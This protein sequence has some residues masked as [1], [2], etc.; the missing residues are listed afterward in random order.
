MQVF[1]SGDRYYDFY[2]QHPVGPVVLFDVDDVEAAGPRDLLDYSPQGRRSRSCLRAV[3][4]SQATAHA[5]IAARL[6]GV[7]PLCEGGT[8]G[9][10][11]RSW[12]R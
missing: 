1:G 12:P 11:R 3:P 2:S 9:R 7:S 6:A 5:I 10:S 8:A 4:L